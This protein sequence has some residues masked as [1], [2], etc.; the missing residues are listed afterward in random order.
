MQQ[1]SVRKAMSWGGM[2]VQR[3]SRKSKKY[4]TVF[5]TWDEVLVSNSLSVQSKRYGQKDGQKRRELVH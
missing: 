3:W 4:V 2:E 1:E 5:V